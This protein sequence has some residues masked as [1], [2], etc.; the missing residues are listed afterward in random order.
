[1][2]GWDYRERRRHNVCIRSNAFDNWARRRHRCVCA[3]R[4]DIHV[5]RNATQGTQAMTE[6][7]DMQKVQDA[8]YDAAVLNQGLVYELIQTIYDEIAIRLG[9]ANLPMTASRGFELSAE[10]VLAS[11]SALQQ[12]YL[13]IFE[14]E[15]KSQMAI[16]SN[17]RKEEKGL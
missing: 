1:M 10:F 2:G 14:A 5:F 4:A 8:G 7:T 3:Y 13:L 15:I 9:V 16:I 6:K 12:L 17:A 11:N